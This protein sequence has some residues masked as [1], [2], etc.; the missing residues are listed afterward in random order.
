MSTVKHKDTGGEGDSGFLT[1]YQVYEPHKVGLP[2][3]VVATRQATWLADVTHDTNFPRAAAAN[4]AGLCGAFAFPL[5]AEGK[6]QGV[7]ELF[8]PMVVRPDDDL[9][10]LMEALGSQIGLFIHRGRLG[11]ELQAQKETAEAANAAKD[12]FLATLS[13]ELRTPLTPILIWAGGT[14]QQPDLPPDIAEGL[15]MICRNVELEARLIDDLL[16]LT[17]ITRGKL[18]LDRRPADVH[19]LLQQTIDIVRSDLEAR[20]LILDLHLEA[21]NPTVRA[22]AARLQQVFWNVLRNAIKFTGERGTV[23][24]RTSNPETERLVIEVSD[25]GVG[26]APESL[27]KIF[28][29]FEQVGERRE[30]LGLGLAIS[31][32]VVEMHGGTICAESAGAGQGALFRIEFAL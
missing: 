8:S 23:S 28:D 15:R 20:E 31:K 24:I 3:R 11:K 25:N 26:I 18:K 29:A 27:E 5:F 12:R 7:L 16:D 9:F 13:H 14:V 19:Q 22:D 1:E 17:R 10:Q 6:I 4:R 2:G 30:G 21:P 32:A